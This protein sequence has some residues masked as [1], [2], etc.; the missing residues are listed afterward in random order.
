MKRQEI[1]LLRSIAGNVIAIH[2]FCLC[3]NTNWVATKDRWRYLL[4]GGRGLIAGNAAMERLTAH[5]YEAAVQQ[6]T[7]L[8]PATLGVI[9]ATGKNSGSQTRR[10]NMNYIARAS[11]AFR[12]E[13]SGLGMLRKL[14]AIALA[15]AIWDRLLEKMEEKSMNQGQVDALLPK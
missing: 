11:Q 3:S 1:D 7:Q 5:I 4:L 8:E 15:A 13:E 6:T 2:G 12:E 9:L 10:T 14:A